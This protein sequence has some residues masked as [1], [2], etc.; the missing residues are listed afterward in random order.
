MMAIGK[1]KLYADI[2]YLLRVFFVGGSIHLSLGSDLYLYGLLI[3]NIVM[4]IHIYSL[5][6]TTGLF[7]RLE[8]YYKAKLANYI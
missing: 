5:Y 8:I 7:G 6:S 4:N 2:D 1:A 3:V